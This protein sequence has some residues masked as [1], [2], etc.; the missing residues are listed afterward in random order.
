[1]KRFWLE[2]IIIPIKCRLDCIS[3]NA[4][5]NFF[6]TNELTAIPKALGLI[7]CP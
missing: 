4:S 2:E 7:E 1:M 5:G 3:T 6:A